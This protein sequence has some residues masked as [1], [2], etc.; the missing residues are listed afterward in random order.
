MRQHT[1]NFDAL[2]LLGALLVLFNHSMELSADRVIG[3]AGQS[4]STLGVKIFFCISG[5]LVATSWMRDPDPA[6]FLL[7]RARRIMPALAV[8]VIGSVLVIG[9]AFTTLPLADFAA[10]PATF[11]YLGNLV[12]YTSYSLPGVFTTLPVPHAVNGSLWTL[13]VEVTLYAL[14]PLYVLAGRAHAAALGGLFLIAI[15]L[16]TYF[17]VVRPPFFVVAGTE[18]WTAAALVPYFVGGA[19]L[20]VLRLERYLN[21][22]VGLLGILVLHGL[23]PRLGHGAEIALCI[24]LPYATIALGRASWPVLRQ[25]GRW[26]EFSYGI[27]LWAFPIQQGV[28]QLLGPGIG[29]PANIA[30]A[31]PVTLAMAALSFHLVEKPALRVGA[32]RRETAPSRE[33]RLGSRA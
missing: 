6:R 32:T 29:G 12:F 24:L 33:D 7:R 11:R 10:H 5:Y 3:F 9:P 18:F 4:I 1:N 8:V 21:A 20:A 25:A 28:V 14:V 27:Y 2:R 17:F 19:L 30:L 13:P 16:S 15:G 22:A 26:G 31:L 23:A